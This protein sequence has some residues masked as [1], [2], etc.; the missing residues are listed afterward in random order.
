MDDEDLAPKTLRP[1]P[2]DLDVLSVEALG[3]YIVEL[4]AEIRRARDAIAAKQAWRNEADT[5]FKS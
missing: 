5:F 3:E 4:E 1:K 2:T